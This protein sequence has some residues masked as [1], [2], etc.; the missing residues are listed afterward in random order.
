MRFIKLIFIN[1]IIFFIL[2]LIIET[3]FGY[4]FKDNNFGFY[5]RKERRINWVTKSNF[6]DQHYTFA[7]KRNFWGF[8]GE[9][10][11]PKDVEIIFQGGSTGNQRMHPEELTIVGQLNKLFK[12]DEINVKI[13]N[14]STDGKSVQGYINDFNYWF[15]KIPNLKPK[16]II[17]F[18]G[19]NDTFISAEK[20]WDYKVSNESIEKVKDYIKNNSIFIDKYKTFKNKYFPRN[21][22]AYEPSSNNLYDGF[23]YTDFNSAKS[24]DLTQNQEL[25]V[26]IKQFKK[27]LN[28]LNNIIIDKR[29]TPVFITQVMFNGLENRDLYSI[30]NELKN[31][32]QSNDYFLIALDELIKMDK[33]DF[34]DPIHTSPK[35]SKKIANTIYPF[36]K[37]FLN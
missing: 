10:F 34:Y 9:E 19:I 17:F 33:G 35:G 31:F 27:K 23:F 6:N 37:D 16:Y 24:K 32:A 2:V 22:L 13:Y 11:N 28:D 3:I 30:N 21:I 1:F 5:M 36:L 29:I 14:S 25:K 8:R 12:D 15:P 7:Y 4:W 18:I 26:K 20:H